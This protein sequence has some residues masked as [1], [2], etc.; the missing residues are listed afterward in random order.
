M[1]WNYFGSWLEKGEHNGI[2]AMVKRALTHEQLKTDGVILRQVVDVVD[3]LKITMSHGA[4]RSYAQSTKVGPDINMTFWLIKLEDVDR[5]K[6]W[7]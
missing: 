7:G 4:S 5:S 3:F 2:G 1:T 6:A